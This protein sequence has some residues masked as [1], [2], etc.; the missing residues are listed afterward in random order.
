MSLA[1][2]SPELKVNKLRKYKSSISF[3]L[4]LMCVLLL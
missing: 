3:N 1:D 4:K 2:L